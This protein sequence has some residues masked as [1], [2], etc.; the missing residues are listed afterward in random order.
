MVASEDRRYR[1]RFVHTMCNLLNMPIP[2][3]Y[4]DILRSMNGEA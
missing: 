2:F 1:K 3:D 4:F